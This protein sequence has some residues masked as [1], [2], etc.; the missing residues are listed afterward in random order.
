MEDVVHVLMGL[1]RVFRKEFISLI[2]RVVRRSKGRT[3]LRETVIVLLDGREMTTSGLTRDQSLLVQ[4]LV[5]ANAR[6]V[7][8]YVYLL[9]FQLSLGFISPALA[10][11]DSVSQYG[12]SWTPEWYDCGGSSWYQGY[13]KDPS[14]IG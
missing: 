14:V 10:A 7:C 8:L 1:R 4:I 11:G 5:V 13:D 9:V 6:K 3:V 2:W 12:N